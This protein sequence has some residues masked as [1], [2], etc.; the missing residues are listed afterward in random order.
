LGF[1]LYFVVVLIIR[2]RAI[3]TARRIR[4]L[5]MVE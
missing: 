5:H 4:A 2:M 1:Q 3:L